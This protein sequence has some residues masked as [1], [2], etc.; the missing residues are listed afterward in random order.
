MFSYSLLFLTFEINART[1][2]KV[3]LLL[4][5]FS[6]YYNIWMQSGQLITEWLIFTVTLYCSLTS[7]NPSMT[8]LALFMTLPNYVHKVSRWLH[9]VYLVS[10]NEEE[11]PSSPSVKKSEEKGVSVVHEVKCKLY[12]KVCFL[13]IRHHIYFSALVSIQLD[14][15]PLVSSVKWPNR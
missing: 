4:K 9:D 3:F 6:D 11:Q 12:V 13:I 8:L 15:V 1:L 5:S 14:F 7:C 10:E 2:F